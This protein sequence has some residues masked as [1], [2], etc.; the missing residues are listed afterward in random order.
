M[1]TRE[2]AEQYG[3]VECVSV[4][5]A[6]FSSPKAAYAGV[7]SNP[8]MVATAPP[9]PATFKKPRRLVSISRSSAG[10]YSRG[11]R[12][13]FDVRRRPVDALRKCL[14]A[15][16]WCFFAYGRS[17]HER[18]GQIHMIT[19]PVREGLIAI[20]RQHPAV[21]PGERQVVRKPVHQIAHV[22]LVAP[23]VSDREFRGSR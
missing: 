14:E 13:K 23:T 7:R 4:A 2:V 16:N 12:I 21:F 5:R 22:V 19:S 18:H 11:P 10:Q 3:H 6:I 1:I 8:N 20:V 9:N 17:E 15:R